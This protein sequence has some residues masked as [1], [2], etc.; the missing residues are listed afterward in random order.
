[1]CTIFERDYVIRGLTKN[2]LIRFKRR[3][4]IGYKEG[5]GVYQIGEN[6]KARI[7]TNIIGGFIKRVQVA[8]YNHKHNTN[9]IFRE[10]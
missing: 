9:I 7:G 5:K 2:D 4:I 3:G 10:S 1:M 8:M 6:Y